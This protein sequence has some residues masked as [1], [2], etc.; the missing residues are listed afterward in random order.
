MIRINLL[1]FRAARKIENVKR[2][3]TIYI[4]T[5][6]LVLVGIGYFFWS[7]SSELSELK[8]EEKKI[9]AELSRHDKEIKLL[10]EYERRID[11]LNAKLEVI[12]DLEMKKTGPVHLLDEVGMAVPSQQLWL[13]SFE[14]KEGMLVLKGTAMDNETVARFMTNLEKSDYI[15]SVDLQSSRMRT[16]PRYELRVSDFVLNCRT[17]AFKEPDAT[18]ESKGKAKRRSKRR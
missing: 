9:Q 17:Y 16:L 8:K 15:S 18:L 13:T 10:D 2:Q 7:L 6:V 11:E 14:E 5:V 4:L 12:K 3:I 1:P